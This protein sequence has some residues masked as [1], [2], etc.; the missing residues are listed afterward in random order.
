MPIARDAS[1]V[2]SSVRVVGQNI[3]VVGGRGAAGM[4]QLG[5]GDAG[6]YPHRVVIELGPD[7]IQRLQPDQQFVVL[8]HH[9]GQGLVHVMVD[10]DHAGHHDM[11]GQIERLVGLAST[12]VRPMVPTAS[13]TLSRT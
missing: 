7:R 3:E 1:I 10:V 13:M 5:H 11:A 12:P 2:L 8:H 9:P 4:N 6:R